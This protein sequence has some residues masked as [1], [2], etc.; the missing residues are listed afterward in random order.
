MRYLTAND[1]FDGK[2]FLGPDTVL[3]LANNNSIV[4]VTTRAEI[5]SDKLED[6][7]G[8]LMPG[9]INVHCHLEL[10]HLKGQIP[11]HTGLAKFATK[12]IQTR[13]QFSFDKVQNDIKTADEQMYNNGIIAVGDICNGTDTIDQKANSRLYYHSFVELIGLKPEIAETVLERGEQVLQSFL[14]SGLSASLAPHAPYSVSKQLVDA[15]CKRNLASAA[16]TSIHNQESQE[17]HDFLFGKTSAMNYLYAFLKLDISYYQ[18]PVQS[19]IQ[20]LHQSISNRPRV[21]VHNTFTSAADVSLAADDFTYWCFC[22]KANLYIEQ[23]LP[24][25]GL[26]PE[27]KICFG[28]DSLASND[29]LNLVEEAN[30]VFKNS[31]FKTETILSALSY[32]GACA[33]ALQERFGSFGVGLTPGINLV[34]IKD[35]TL[36]FEKRLV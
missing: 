33:L 5:P 8:I 12:L 26:F 21:F 35:R 31:D 15:I 27:N 29:S 7:N 22:P 34:S 3:V 17:E 28:T 30:I 25:F 13:Q 32:Q 19:S 16:G 36:Q 11:Q 20:W 14:L 2:Q 1:V 9:F 6:F 10:S 4:A 18:A 24:E 23:H